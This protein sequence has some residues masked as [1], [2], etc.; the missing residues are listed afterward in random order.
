M[1]IRELIC[2]NFN[3]QVEQTLM[4]LIYSTYH[5]DEWHKKKNPQM[6]M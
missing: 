3:L 1:Y 4:S 6:P 5:A 2:F